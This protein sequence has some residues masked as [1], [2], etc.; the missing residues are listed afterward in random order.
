LQ[1]GRNSLPLVMA[2]NRFLNTQ[3]AMQTLS[4]PLSNTQLEILKA[5]SHPLNENDLVE[6]RKTLADF[7]AKR[8]VVAA[9]KT[10]DEKGWTDEDVDRLLNTKLRKRGN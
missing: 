5:F 8:A 9:N 7:F 1:V 3:S 2:F 6:L 10:W 4:Q